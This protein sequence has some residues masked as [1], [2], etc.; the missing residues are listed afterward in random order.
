MPFG[1]YSLVNN[2][3]QKC[4][5]AQRY[6]DEEDNNENAF[7]KFSETY[8]KAAKCE[9]KMNIANPIDTECTYIHGLDILIKRLQ[10]KLKKGSITAA[11]FLVFM[12][13]LFFLVG[14]YAYFLKH[15]K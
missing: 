13:I 4:F 12:M 9:N 3:C 1:S 15:S 7:E 6:D 2:T 8:G 10:G 11:I 14:S 5:G